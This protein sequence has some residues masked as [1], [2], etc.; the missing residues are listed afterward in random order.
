[1]MYITYILAGMVLLGL[2]IFV[3]ELGHLLGHRKDDIF[4]RQQQS[5]HKLSALQ[6]A[7]WISERF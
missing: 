6:C 7:D 2:C 1:M 3:H 5:T 4:I